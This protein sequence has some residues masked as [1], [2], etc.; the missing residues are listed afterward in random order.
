MGLVRL[1]GKLILP[2]SEFSLYEDVILDACCQNIASNDDIWN[3][4]LV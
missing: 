3:M 1:A 4:W 2:K